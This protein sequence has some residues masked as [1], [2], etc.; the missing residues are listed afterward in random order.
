MLPLLSH[1]KKPG[2]GVSGAIIK[3][4]GYVPGDHIRGDATATYGNLLVRWARMS[5]KSRR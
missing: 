5:R 1:A 4:Y 2:P 3:R